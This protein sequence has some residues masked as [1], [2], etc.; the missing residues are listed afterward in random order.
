M[1]TPFQRELLKE[2]KPMGFVEN[3]YDHNGRLIL[4]HPSGYHTTISSKSGEGHTKRKWLSGILKGVQEAESVPGQFE[5]WIWQKWDIP[6]GHEKPCQLS[7]AKEYNQFWQENRETLPHGVKRDQV[8][9]RIR[10]S[11]NFQNV[12]GKNGHNPDDDPNEP[13]RRIWLISQPARPEVVKP[14]VHEPETLVCPTCGSTVTGKTCRCGWY[15]GGVDEK[16]RAEWVRETNREIGTPAP[17]QNAQGAQAEAVQAEVEEATTTESLGLFDPELVEMLK[18]ALAG[19]LMVELATVKD[20]NSLLLEELSA[21]IRE[22]TL[23]IDELAAMRERLQT[24]L[25]VV[26]G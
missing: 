16:I 13:S 4:D 8:M 25:D 1:P 9:G 22:V 5:R 18:R 26:Q 3:G 11:P 14:W 15:Q 20:S 17:P 10:K 12:T 23:R 19:P 2:L 6:P 7:L 24:V 21:Q